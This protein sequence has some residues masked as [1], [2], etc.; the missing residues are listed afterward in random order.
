M[1]HANETLGLKG[2]WRGVDAEE[3]TSVQFTWNAEEFSEFRLFWL[4]LFSGGCLVHCKHLKNV[5]CVHASTMDTTSIYR[6]QD[7]VLQ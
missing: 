6:K 3:E 1:M 5:M 7:V 2:G 4:G